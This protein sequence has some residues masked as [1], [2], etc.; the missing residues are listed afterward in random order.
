MIIS[1]LKNPRYQNEQE[2]M[3]FDLNL[4]RGSDIVIVNIN[5]LNTSIG[6]VIEVYEA[7]EK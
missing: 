2:V 1:I 7:V 3:K 6:S 5:G 4:V